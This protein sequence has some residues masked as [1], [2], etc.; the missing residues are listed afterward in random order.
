MEFRVLGPLE[1]TERG[2]ALALG[3]PRQ[4]VVL[5][6]LVLEANRVVSTDRL[7]DRI[8]GDE[9]PD[10]A[11]AALF[12]YVSRLRKLLGPGRI[13]A[14]PPGYVLVAEPDEIDALRF[15]ALVEEAR[16]QGSDREAAAGLLKEALELWRGSALS[17]LAEYDALRP[18]ITRLEELR[19]GAIEDH[20]EADL[21]LGRHREVV[22][23]LETLTGEHPLRERLWSLLI[24]ALYRSGRQGDALGAYH[25]ARTTLVEE[26]GIDP[27]PE[28]RRLE[29]E[30]LNQDPALDL[31]PVGSPSADGR[32]CARGT[33]LLPAS[34]IADTWWV[35]SPS[36]LLQSSPFGRWDKRQKGSRMGTGRS[37]STCRSPVRVLCKANPSVTPCSWQSTTSTRP[38]VS[39]VRASRYRSSMT[40]RFPRRLRPMH[41]RSWMTPGRSR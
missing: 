30:V 5:A 31:P 16:R 13:Q 39:T 4:R 36:A 2:A 14:R 25:R 37:D 34:S 18:A 20:V 1:V 11:R 21:A 10:A 7:I 12:A 19:L 35:A 15:A 33:H 32:D 27:S 9:P 6:Y 17:D 23:Q 41:S 40:R 38:V 3:G 8:W 26:L 24:L 22:G 29:T 28:L